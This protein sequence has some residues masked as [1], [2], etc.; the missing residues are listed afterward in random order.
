MSFA[1]VVAPWSLSLHHQT[2]AWLPSGFLANLWI[3]AVG[4]GSW[5]GGDAAD[6]RRDQFANGPDD[7]LGETVA[8]IDDGHI[9]HAG[10]MTELADDQELQTRL[11]SLSLDAHQ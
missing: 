4:D 9:V 6:A 5:H 2:G 7:Y 1:V 3:G 11:L 10:S 8:V